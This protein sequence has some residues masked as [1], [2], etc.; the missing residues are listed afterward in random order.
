V[1]CFTPM[2]A[3]VSIRVA[4]LSFT[5]GIMG[6]MRTDAGMPLRVSASIVFRRSV[7][8]GALGSI[9]FAV[10]SSSVVIVTAMVEGILLRRSVSRVT[11]VDLVIIWIRQSCRERI[12]KHFRVKPASASM[13]GYGSE[14]LAMETVSP[15]SFSASRCNCRS[16]SFFG[17]HTE[18]WGM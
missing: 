11:R 3:S 18:K 12:S 16:R 4:G 5:W 9:S 1:T 13:R 15:F 2:L 7:E 8:D 10:A 14:L 6:S 17:L